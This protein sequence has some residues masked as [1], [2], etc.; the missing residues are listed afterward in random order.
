[1]RLLFLA[2]DPAAGGELSDTQLSDH[3]RHPLPN[4]RAV[5][6]RSNF[7][8]SLDGSIQG[9]D[10]R[11][12]SLNTPSDHHVFAL[13]RAHADA[14]LVGA[15]TVRAEGYRAV[16]L[17][18]WQ[19]E[20]RVREGLS[21]FPLL[22]IVTRS[23]ALD[24]GI[25]ANGDLEVGRV[26]VLTSAGKTDEQLAP[27][28]ESGVEVVQLSPDTVDLVAAV[29]H[30]SAAGYRRVLCEGGSRLHRDLVAADLLD[31]MSL[32]L[33][34]VMVGGEGR[35]TTVGPPLPAPAAFR[36]GSALHDEDGTLFV[37]YRRS[38]PLNSVRPE[39]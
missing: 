36:L 17:A 26:M 29:D 13:H 35:R 8:T 6:L 34:P 30:L 18:P 3:Y 2:D 28:A 14:V 24:P 19:R 38:R 32:T 12:G 11:S 27:F 39:A 31:E 15:E 25:A 23:L 7:V 5:W 33:A 16:D 21:D 1:M 4:E 22:A 10:G 37:N 20:L 9:T